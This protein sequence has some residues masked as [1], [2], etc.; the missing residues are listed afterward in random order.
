MPESNKTTLTELSARYF[1]GGTSGI[2]QVCPQGGFLV[3][4][5]DN[6]YAAPVIWTPQSAPEAV[7][8]LSKL[9]AS[10]QN[11]TTY[12]SPTSVVI[13]LEK[14]HRNDLGAITLGRD[15]RNDIRIT[16]KAVSRFHA[17]F[18]D[19]HNQFFVEDKNSSNGTFVNGI[20]L[21]PNIPVPL[22]IGAELKFGIVQALLI[23]FDCLVELVRIVT[24]FE[25]CN[26][27]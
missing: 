10:P 18:Y 21:Q 23:D 12:A 6:S 15:D 11:L 14:R 1:G 4:P 5:P 7:V 19:H 26:E 8:T 2:R 16:S 9:K 27:A 24:Q 22:V 25:F 17:F 3:V 20:E 13:P